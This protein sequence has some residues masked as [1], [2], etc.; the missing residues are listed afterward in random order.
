M[1][2]LKPWH[3]WEMP[4]LWVCAVVGVVL[5]GISTAVFWKVGQ[6]ISS[7]TLQATPV[8]AAATARNPNDPDSY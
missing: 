3:E 1:A 6:S 5:V 2:K 4:P 7:S 8:P